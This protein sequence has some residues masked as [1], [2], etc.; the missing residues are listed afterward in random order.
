MSFNNGFICSICGPI[1]KA[2]SK[3]INKVQHNVCPVCLIIVLPWVRPL[4]DRAG[5]CHCCGST[6]F[7]LAV[8]KGHILRKCETCNEVYNTDTEKTIRKGVAG[9]ERK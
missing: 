8:H 2:T 6:K 1:E 3:T 4:K 7:K 5:R 9:N